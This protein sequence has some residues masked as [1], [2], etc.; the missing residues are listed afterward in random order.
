M[1]PADRGD[2]AAVGEAEGFHVGRGPGPRSGEPNHLA[3]GIRAGDFDGSRVRAGSGAQCMQ[4]RPAWR[5]QIRANHSPEFPSCD[6]RASRSRSAGL[7]AGSA[8][9]GS[10]PVPWVGGR[11]TARPSEPRLSS[12]A[13]PSRTSPTEPVRSTGVRATGVPTDRRRSSGHPHPPRSTRHRPLPARRASTRRREPHPSR[14]PRPISH[15][16]RP[17]GS[18]II[19]LHRFR[20][21]GSRQNPARIFSH[22]PS[23]HQKI[24][25]QRRERADGHIVPTGAS[26]IQSNGAAI[27]CPNGSAAIR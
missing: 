7:N 10:L 21:A 25:A 23:P 2:G 13:A 18:S 15:A 17:A 22:T 24:P 19:E 14:L 11:A 20:S 6:S 9:P 3:E 8:Y 16:R 1:D 5:H 26:R 4:S 12:P 27:G